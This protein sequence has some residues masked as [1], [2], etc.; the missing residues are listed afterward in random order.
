MSSIHG[1]EVEAN[2]RTARRVF[3]EGVNERRFELLSELFSPSYVGPNGDRGARSFASSME[4]LARAFPD[5]HYVIEDVIAA[6]DRVVLRFRLTGT[7]R[8]KFAAF[9]PTERAVTGTGI[10]IFQLEGGRIVRAWVEND[11]LGFQQQLAA[12]V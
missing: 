2:A 9:E 3:E 6:H 1:I 12:A 7:H 10:V 11:R 4:G 5:L 8:G